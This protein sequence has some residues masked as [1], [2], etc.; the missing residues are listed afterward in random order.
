M[1][2]NVFCNNTKTKVLLEIS[3]NDNGSAYASN[4]D[5]AL[6]QAEQEIKLLDETIETVNTLKPQ[7][8]KIDY[9]LVK[10][11]ENK[12]LLSEL[13][14][15]QAHVKNADALI[16]CV[17]DNNAWSKEVFGK[18]LKARGMKY[19]AIDNIMT[20]P[21][22]YPPLLGDEITLLR[23][24]EQ[25]TYA[26]AYMTLEAEMLGIGCCVIGALGNEV[27]KI[28][29]EISKEAKEKLNLND[30]QCIISMLTLGYEKDP[31]P[32][33]K[34]RKDFNEVISLEKLGNNF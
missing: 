24:V 30:N 26:I 22:Y 6:L 23:S 20:I 1:K 8:D 15:G 21:A 9:A 16:V 14:C 25:I 29:P 28:L 11:Q 2:F 12:E 3:E 17:A 4:I 32:A 27:T 13:S 31:Q 19:E 18:V 34:M 10:S 7:C 33:N 5:D